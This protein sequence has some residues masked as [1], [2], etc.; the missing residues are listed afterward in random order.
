MLLVKPVLDLV[1]IEG[2]L[3]IRSFI[4]FPDATTSTPGGLGD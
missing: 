3:G 4:Y 1:T 2:G